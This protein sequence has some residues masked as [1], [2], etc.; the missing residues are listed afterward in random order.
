MENLRAS[1]PD[2]SEDDR[3][4]ARL[5]SEWGEQKRMSALMGVTNATIRRQLNLDDENHASDF[6]RGRRLNY[7]AGYR[8]DEKGL[9]LKAGFDEAYMAGV[10]DRLG[11]EAELDIT[12][13]ELNAAWFQFLAARQTFEAGRLDADHF[14]AA[15][16]RLVEKLG[17]VR[18]GARP[19]TAGEMRRETEIGG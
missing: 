3:T 19:M 17:Q 4:F 11:A 1:A 8:G 2:Q 10:R 7:A 15:R 9:A 12:D 18:T 14:D 5:F 16:N 6:H 13:N